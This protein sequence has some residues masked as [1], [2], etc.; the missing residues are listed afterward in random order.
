MDFLRGF[1]PPAANSGMFLD[2]VEPEA[3]LSNKIRIPSLF[4]REA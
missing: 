4:M 1:A 3:S 2:A